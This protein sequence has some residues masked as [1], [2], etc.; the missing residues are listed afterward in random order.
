[1]RRGRLFWGIV[2][3]GL[4]ALLLLGN[5]GLLT[6]RAWRVLWPSLLVLLGVWVLVA[7]LLGRRAVGS[8][9]VSVPL[10]P[11]TSARLILRHGAG[12]LDVRGGA[13]AG[14]LY[15]GTFGGG[16][17]HQEK[18][19]GDGVLARLSVPHDVF[20]GWTAHRWDEGA[21][22]WHV[23]LAGRVRLALEL[24]TGASKTTMD[25]TGL[26]VAELQLRTGASSTV[27]TLPACAGVTTVKVQ[28]GA[29]S[30]RL[31]VPSG[32]AARIRA[33]AGLASIDIDTARFAKTDGEWRSPD[34]DEATNKADVDIDTGVGSIQVR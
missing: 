10:G 27:V 6:A 30:V 32:V 28:S 33:H 26:D 34:Y 3:V 16:L 25:L 20:G 8:E 12:E 15:D 17:D 4:G 7:R 24:Q 22:D 23:R 1:M 19:Q 31:N 13:R 2:F 29:A 14:Q 9:T 5:L 18:V 21:L 11:A